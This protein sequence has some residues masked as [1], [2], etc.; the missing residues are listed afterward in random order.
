MPFTHWVAEKA[1]A[2]VQR[3]SLYA[4]LLGRDPAHRGT[5]F[6]SWSLLG[7][8]FNDCER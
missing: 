3:R 6:E 2:G 7:L 8:W 5:T 1:P 4:Q